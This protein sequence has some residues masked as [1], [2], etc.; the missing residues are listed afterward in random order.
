VHRVQRR[1]LQIQLLGRG[2]DDQVGGGDAGMAAPPGPAH[3]ARPSGDR[4]IHG[5]PMERVEEPIGRTAKNDCLPPLPSL[6]RD[7][8]VDG[9]QQPVFWNPRSRFPRLLNCVAAGRGQFLPPLAPPRVPALKDL[10]GNRIHSLRAS[11]ERGLWWTSVCPR[12][13]VVVRSAPRTRLA[14]PA[15]F[16]RVP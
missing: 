7:E 6:N 8:P 3:L 5:R 12:T 9:R 4:L 15:A 1:K 11:H 13:L 16:A 10:S 2:G 14:M